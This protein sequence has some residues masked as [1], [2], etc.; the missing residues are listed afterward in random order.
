M[1]IRAGISRRFT[2]SV[3]AAFA[4]L[5]AMVAP[6]AADNAIAIPIVDLGLTVELR[7]YASVPDG[8]RPWR[9][10]A[11]INQFATT[12]DRTFFLEDFDGLIYELVRDG[13]AGRSSLFFD[14]KAAIAASTDRELD[15]TNSFHGGLRGMA[16]H[17][18][19]ATNG[20]LYTS[21]METRPR[22]PG[23]FDY[24]GGDHPNPIAADGVV[25]EWTYDH[26]A[27]AVDPQSYRLLLRV[28]MPV[29][30][31]PIKQMAFNPYAVPGDSDYGLLYI[32]HGDGSVQSATAGG[33]QV[34]DALG[35]ILRVDP[36]ASAG[37][38]YRVPADNPF[39]GDPSM[40]DEVYALGFRNPHHLSFAE[41]DSGDVHLVAVDVGRDNVEEVNIIVAGGNYGWSEREGTFVH[42]PSGDLI[43]GI[44]PLP[45]NE[46]ENG[47]IYPAAQVGHIGPRGQGFSGQ[48]IA[49]GFVVD[50]GSELS[51][52]YFY[53]DFPKTGNVFHSSFDDMLNAV[54]ELDPNDPSRDSPTD[55]TQARTG[56]ASILFDH[57]SDP[58]TPSLERESL[59]DVFNDAALYDGSGRADV[60]FGQGPDG[61]MYISSKKNGQ[62]YLVTNSLPPSATCQGLLA[63]TTGLTG[64][65]GD[66][67]IVGTTG[68][69]VIDGKGGNDVICGRGGADTING[70]SG[71]DIINAGWGSDVVRGGDGDDTI[72]A[73]PGLDDVEG[74]GGDDLIRGGKGGDRLVGNGGD[75]TIYGG[76][77]K[78]RIF[79]FAGNDRLFGGAG[80][81]NLR[82]GAGTDA[83][84]GG[85]GVDVCVDAETLRGCE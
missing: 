82:G 27:G 32:S 36:R 30:D 9:P 69:D 18:D 59:L 34:N 22:N 15:L 65:E 60:R 17:P 42:L 78:D 63:T 62:I 58:S 46:A 8:T 19:F 56:R 1:T 2:V 38:P 51:G 6:A 12:G 4:L 68:P 79:G 29:Y 77:R 50:N 52:Q 49:G 54:T 35:K 45:A 66:D 26:A 14:V 57:D 48:A 85:A 24:L 44:A 73:G 67:V 5:A 41:D 83:V 84:T 64:T 31:H 13:K 10:R 53:S 80:E 25:V 43:D 3:C 72:F 20:L 75:D 61:E 21:F 40:L 81:D 37:Q 39:V 70:G 23:A 76:D 74:E 16:F 7:P 33:G 47:F 71:A 55:L 11:R 28:A